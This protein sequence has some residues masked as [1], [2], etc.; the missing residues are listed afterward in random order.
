MFEPPK[1]V[2]VQLDGKLPVYMQDWFTEIAGRG[3]ETKRA[4]VFEDGKP[5]CSLAIVIIRNGLGMKQG[6]N[7]P[8]ARLCGLIISE[9]FSESQKAQ[10]ARRLIR[11]LPTDVSY[12]LTLAKKFDY[13]QFLS[14]GFQPAIED[15]YVISPARYRMLPESFSKMTKRH[16]R[17]AGRELVVSTTTTA[18]AFINFYEANLARRHFT[19]YIPLTIAR[20]ILEEGLRRGQSSIFTATRRDTGEIDAAIA[21]LW[22]G[23]RYYYWMPTHRV[24]TKGETKPDQGAVK[25]L[26][27]SAIQDAA[28]RGLTF[29]F[30]GVGSGLSNQDGKSRLYEGMGAESCVRYR[31]KRETTLERLLGRTREPVKLLIRRTFGRFIALKF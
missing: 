21:C 7:L 11:E 16:I 14:E 6:Y 22:D 4:A 18:E 1:I 10:I 24:P 15:N 13:D 3:E 8:W 23:D 17:H 25:L 19:P 5:I 12:F 9:G 27:W 31:V 20:D 28:A 26:L 2:G 30:D 29:D